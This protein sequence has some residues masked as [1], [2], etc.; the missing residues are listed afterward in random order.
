MQALEFE[1]LRLL[2]PEIR[3]WGEFSIVRDPGAPILFLGYLLGLVGLLI[4]LPAQRTE[5]LRR[6]EADEEAA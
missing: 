5:A 6:V 2:F 4:K 3:Y 1:G